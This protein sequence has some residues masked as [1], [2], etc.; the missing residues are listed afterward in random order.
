MVEITPDKEL[1]EEI[2]IYVRVA[3]DI[4]ESEDNSIE[5]QLKII[6]E[7]IDEHFPKCSYKEYIDYDKSGYTIEQREEYQAMK[8]SLIAGNSK[9]MIVKD[10]SRITRNSLG[11][12]EMEQLRD[13]GVRIISI[14]DLR[15]FPSVDEWFDIA[16]CFLFEENP[17]SRSELRKMVKQ[18]KK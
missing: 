14:R 6:H 15:D 16:V 12:Y 3:T 4:K 5:N 8:K 1:Q 10:F 2:S 7:Y 17:P 13:K 11:L 18:A 9:I